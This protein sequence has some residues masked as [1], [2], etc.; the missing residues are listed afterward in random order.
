MSSL[1]FLCLIVGWISTASTTPPR[2][3]RGYTTHVASVLDSAVNKD[4]S[5]SVSTVVYPWGG[6]DVV[7]V[8][9]TFPNVTRCVLF[10]QE[11]LDP[12]AGDGPSDADVAVALAE[13]GH[14]RGLGQGFE[15]SVTLRTF[16]SR[17]G[18]VAL[19]RH[20]LVDDLG[21]QIRFERRHHNHVEIS[22]RLPGR[23]HQLFTVR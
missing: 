6:V 23:R 20:V 16:C 3:L 1:L 5:Q 9:G 18:L 4:I 11:A 13:F 14:A 2:V 10:G 8:L 22:A 19:L 17:F 12:T 21:G 7:A 15:L